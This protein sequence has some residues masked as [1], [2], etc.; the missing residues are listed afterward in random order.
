MNIYDKTPDEEESVMQED[1]SNSPYL[2]PSV[3]STWN[4]PV[5]FLLKPKYRGEG[6]LETGLNVD[7]NNMYN[8][9]CLKSLIY[10]CIHL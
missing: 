1:G 9:K 2:T 4:V 8:S 6:F 3:T 7:K 10:E 5:F